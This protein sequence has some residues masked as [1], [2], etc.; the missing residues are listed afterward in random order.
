MSF[1]HYNS[2]QFPFAVEQ[3]VLD[4]LM[5]WILST[6]IF[7]SSPSQV[8]KHL[9]TSCLSLLPLLVFVVTPRFSHNASKSTCNHLY[10]VVYFGIAAVFITLHSLFPVCILS[11]LY[12][13]SQLVHRH[14]IALQSVKT[15]SPEK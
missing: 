10:Q 15:N 4:S 8:R 5:S 3:E 13:V 14:G 1:S 6:K 9:N 7:I 2:I 12:T 11:S